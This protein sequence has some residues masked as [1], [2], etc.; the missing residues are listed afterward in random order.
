[1]SESELA[2]MRRTTLGC[3][4]QFFGLLPML[5]ARDNVAMA[6]RA[7]RLERDEVEDRVIDL[8]ERRREA[9]K[10]A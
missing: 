1:M 7:E 3:L 8:A 9:D 5:D 6:L 10:N 2:R 4:F